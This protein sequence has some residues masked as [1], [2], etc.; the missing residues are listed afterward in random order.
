MVHVIDLFADIC[1]TCAA[2]Y[3]NRAAAY[4]MMN[5]Y[6]DALI[7]IR[8]SL[9]IDKTFVKVSEAMALWKIVNFFIQFI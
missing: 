6:K 5:K 8:E 7:D 2:Y 1:P 9:R 3:G 4:M